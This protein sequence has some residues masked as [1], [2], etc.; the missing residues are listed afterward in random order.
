MDGPEG[1]LNNTEITLLFSSASD[2]THSFC[3]FLVSVVYFRASNLFLIFPV[4]KLQ[5]RCLAR[6]DV[7]QGLKY[8]KKK[9]Y[10]QMLFMDLLDVYIYAR[11]NKC[12]IKA[13]SSADS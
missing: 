13:L 10:T 9:T 1:T 8:K 12:V 4:S 5:L 2:S 3:F 11:L 6:L 7:Y